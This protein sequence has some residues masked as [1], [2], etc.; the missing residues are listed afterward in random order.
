MEARFRLRRE[1]ASSMFPVPQRWPRKKGIGKRESFVEDLP[2]IA[3]AARPKPPRIDFIQRNIDHAAQTRSRQKVVPRLNRKEAI[4]NTRHE[5][6]VLPRYVRDQRESRF[7]DAPVPEEV[8]CPPGTRLLTDG[9]KNEALAA[10][11]SRKEELEAAFAR[12]PLRIETQSMQKRHTEMEAQLREIDD[13]IDKLNKT[14]VFVE[15]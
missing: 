10:L 13:S 4:L 5:P 6:G 12:A 9:E 8:R 11:R 14:Y 2:P 1:L 3:E 7:A 15:A